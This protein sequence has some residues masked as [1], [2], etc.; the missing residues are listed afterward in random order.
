M[1][2]RRFDGA[3]TRR[4]EGKSEKS[5]GGSIQV[6]G[7]S[8]GGG[9]HRG[10]R[11]RLSVK[12]QKALKE[13]FVSEEVSKL[14]RLHR[15]KVERKKKEEDIL[16]VGHVF[17]TFGDIL[18]SLP[19]SLKAVEKNGDDDS[20]EEQKEKK[21]VEKVEIEK[22]AR[23][24]GMSHS[25]WKRDVGKERAQLECVQRHE[26]FMN[27]GIE[28]LRTHLSNTVD[29]HGNEGA[30]LIKGSH[31]CKGAS[32]GVANKAIQKTDMNKK[33]KRE[34]NEERREQKRLLAESANRFQK[35]HNKTIGKRSGP[36][37]LI[38]KR[39]RIGEKREKIM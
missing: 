34:V 27:M 29:T 4:D 28:A 38:G 13:K 22:V 36:S 3:K 10:K 6:G 9:M 37:L 16:K 39:G 18:T 33:K 1:G 35:K 32:E 14:E 20:G 24:G 19:A 5:K 12:L 7:V 26:A 2:K 31:K 23:G 11:K 17:S 15:E 25:K 30:P 8:K 21:E